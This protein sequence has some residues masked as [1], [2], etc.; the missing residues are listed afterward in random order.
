MDANI[1]IF[2]VIKAGETAK[3]WK[4]SGIDCIP[5]E[6]LKNGV[7]IVVLY[8]IFNVCFQSSQVPAAWSKTVINPL[9]KSS[10]KDL[11]DPMSYKGIALAPTMYKMYSGILNER[12]VKWT[13]DNDLIVD[14]Q[15]GFRKNVAH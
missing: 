8:S 5:T 9:P 12:I 10:S 13:E 1:S 6:V 7:S 11:K 15:N 3:L 14:E 4:A 2:E